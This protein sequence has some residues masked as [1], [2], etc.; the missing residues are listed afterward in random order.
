MKPQLKFT[1][2]YLKPTLLLSVLYVAVCMVAGTYFEEYEGM[3][4]SFVHGTYTE[5]VI[6]G[7]EVNV[8]SLIMPL[9]F[10]LNTLFPDIQ[11]YGWVLI[12]YNY[13]T[14]VFAGL[15]L[16]RICRWN[17]GKYEGWFPYVLII[18]LMTDNI[19]NLSTTRIAFIG[20]GVL[21]AYIAS[22]RAEGKN[23]TA[24]QELLIAAGFFFYAMLRAEGVL[25]AAV[26]YII[27]LFFFRRWERL[28]VWPLLFGFAIF[29]IYHLTMIWYT[30]EAI[31]VYYVY[32]K[33]L[34]DRGS[35]AA[36]DTG[37]LSFDLNAFLMHG[38]TDREHFT[39]DFYQQLSQEKK[40][41]GIAS[42]LNG[43]TP[44]AFVASVRHSMGDIDK[45]KHVIILFLLNVIFYLIV[46]Q[47]N[48]LRNVLL[49]VVITL[50]PL[51]VCFNTIAPARFLVPY[52]AVF[53]AMYIVL[54][55]Q[56]EQKRLQWLWLVLMLVSGTNSM[57][58]S[59]RAAAK[60]QQKENKFEKSMQQLQALTKQTENQSPVIIYQLDM[61]KFF[62]A[63]PWK[64]LH[65]QHAMLLN[66]Y[67]LSSY[68]FYIERWK[69][70][71]HCN[72]LSLKEKMEYMVRERNKVIIDL[73]EAKFLV[74]YFSIKYKTPV[75]LKHLS[76]FDDSLSVC[77]P[78]FL[79]N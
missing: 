1:E 60:Y 69:K 66:M 42:I 48:V 31:S 4:S 14:F 9:Y 7:T 22:R 65:R 25:I 36:T 64:P 54:Q 62:P 24:W 37:M 46:Q 23:I 11:V 73:D 58:C 61:D 75:E 47:K 53:A 3:F 2:I 38:I 68:D 15:V 52:Y 50:L 33:E 12:F 28:S 79:P 21:F 45:S 39:R 43:L 32:E 49:A 17:I 30:S 78:Y 41:D 35:I 26:F 56:L 74:E 18:L 19:V 67:M 55:L 70:E 27:V 72:P 29:V 10:Y 5:P 59:V 40:D 20:T 44:Q 51:L 71:C 57:A 63:T 76:D 6:K 8:H 13:L 16:Y 77:E 34:V